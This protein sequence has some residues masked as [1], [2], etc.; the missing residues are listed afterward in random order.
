VHAFVAAYEKKFGAKPDAMAALGYDSMKFLAAAMER[1]SALDGPTLREEIAKTTGFQGVTGTISLGAD[2]NPINKK[3]VV[4][5]IKDGNL[6]LRA[7]VDP[8][9]S[10]APAPDTTAAAVPEAAAATK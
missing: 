2:R 9:A 8:A 10:A 5:E 3:L 1:A 6:V 7:T 4:L